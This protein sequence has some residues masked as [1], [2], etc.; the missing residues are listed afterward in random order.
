MTYFSK[1]IQ[2]CKQLNLIK[3]HNLLWHWQEKKQD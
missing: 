3:K 1:L 2:I